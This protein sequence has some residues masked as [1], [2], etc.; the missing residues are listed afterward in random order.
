MK[1]KTS[2][3]ALSEYV[4][5]QDDLILEELLSCKDMHAG[6]ADRHLPLCLHVKCSHPERFSPTKKD[7][8]GSGLR[9]RRRRGGYVLRFPGQ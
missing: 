3:S 4:A 2:A 7:Q 1:M 5:H 8:A 6:S 9:T